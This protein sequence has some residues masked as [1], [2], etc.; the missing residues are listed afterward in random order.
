MLC[1]CVPAEVMLSPV[2]ILTPGHVVAERHNVVKK[3]EVLFGFG[4]KLQHK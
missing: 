3:H 1:V 2:V 4:L